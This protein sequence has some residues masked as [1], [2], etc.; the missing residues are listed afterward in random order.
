MAADTTAGT[1]AQTAPAR[2]PAAILAVAAF[3]AFL[4]TFN[5]TFLNV[6]FAPI[7]ADLGV[8][9]STVQWL[10]TAYMLG[11]AVMV[12]VSAFAYRSFPT[13]PLFCATA[14]LLVIGSVIGGVATNFAVLLVGRIVQALGTGMLIPIGMNITLEIAPREKLGTYMGIMGAMT[15][16]GPS[17]S[18]I[19]AGLILAVANWSMLLW[20]FAGLSA[21]CL[22]SGAVI[23]RDIAHLTHPRLDAA[24]VALIGIAL[25]GILYGVSTV[26]SGSVPVACVA[27]VVGIVALVLFVKRQGKLTEPLIDLRPLKIA[28]FTVGVIVNMLSLLTIFAM[29]IIVP[30]FMQSVLGTEPLVASLTLFPAILCSCVVSPLAGR[31]YD[32]QGPG[33]ILPAGF[34]CIAV[35]SVLTGAFIATASP[36]VLAVIYIPVICGSAL[37]IGP[38]QSFALSRLPFELNPHGVTIM[39][40]GF[41]IAG[42]IGSS[43]F[44]GVYAA[45]SA[46]AM[47]G[48]APFGD[49]CAQAMLVTGILVGV[50]GLAGLALAL[51]VRG[52]ARKPS[53][54]VA[55]AAAAAAADELAA[56]PTVS[57]IMKTEVYTLLETALVAEALELFAA[58]GISGA[59]VVDGAGRV[60]GFISDGDV[61]AA[62]ADQVPAFKSAWSFV[63]EREN[64]DFDRTLRET[65]AAP[66]SSIATK[67]VI[68]VNVNDDMGKVA[69]VLS[70]HH[71]K[72]APVLDGDVMVGIINRSNITGYAVRRYLSEQ[73]A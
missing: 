58:K 41:Q 9:V 71:L 40:T 3:A 32:K 35:F 20:V 39:S 56:E 70:E 72:K 27:A 29:N 57:A 53:I 21:L 49:A 64:A 34:L 19:L 26:F 50:V 59:P 14:A 7:M 63:V 37:V 47:A 23:L 54:E 38:V 4:A 42:C 6:G 31:I 73:R 46:G 22:L 25:I 5:E 36:V 16:L 12:P 69:R 66:V 30:T 68:C 13:R 61:M 1:T 28:P 24:S 43:V 60:T 11:A 44:T 8:D 2:K 67:S 62:V 15:T 51:W 10:A 48:G 45:V 65:M 55:G 17:S 33:I 18:V 52:Q